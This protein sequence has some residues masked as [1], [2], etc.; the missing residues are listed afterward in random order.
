M[1]R[2]AYANL[3]QSRAELAHRSAQRAELLE[4]KNFLDL[5][6]IEQADQAAPLEFK[7]TALPLESFERRNAAAADQG[8]D[9]WTGWEQWLAA[10]LRRERRLMTR[11]TGEAIEALLE[12]E[13]VE[14]KRQ[15]DG[16]RLEFE[17]QVAELKALV[18]AERAKIIDMPSRRVS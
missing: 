2:R 17:Q 10:R 12:R 15:L 7:T 5:P 18:N 14:H 16:L 6:P 1:L 13:R 9:Y 11:A 3:A 4:N 8:S